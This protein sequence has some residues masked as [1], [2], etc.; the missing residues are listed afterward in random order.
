[1]TTPEPLIEVYTPE[2]K[3]EFLMAN[4]VDEADLAWAEEE[5]RKLGLEPGDFWTPVPRD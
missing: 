1:M 5:V 4:V 3:A 2:R